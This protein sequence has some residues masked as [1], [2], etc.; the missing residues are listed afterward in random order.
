MINKKKWLVVAFDLL[1]LAVVFW[2]ARYWYSRSF[3][4]YEDDLTIIPDAFGK[5]FESLF[6]FLFAYVT[7]LRG[8]ARPFSDGFIIF[9]PGWVGGLEAFGVLILSA[10]CSL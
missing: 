7:Q 8:H 9:S 2:V 3:G 6:R 5:S 4:L 10:I 1:I